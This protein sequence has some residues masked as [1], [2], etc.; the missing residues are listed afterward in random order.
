MATADEFEE[1][2]LEEDE[3]GLLEGEFEE[4]KSGWQNLKLKA[5]EHPRISCGGC[6]LIVSFAVDVFIRFDPIVTGLGIA[7]A[8]LVGW[9]GEDLLHAFIPAADPDQANQ[10]VTQMLDNYPMYKDQSPKAKI[11]RLF[12]QGSPELYEFAEQEEEFPIQQRRQLPPPSQRREVKKLSGENVASRQE[13][14]TDERI[15]TWF[16]QGVI[17]DEQLIRLLRHIEKRSSHGNRDGNGNATT[18]EHEAAPEEAVS[19]QMEPL[20]PVGWDEQKEFRFAGAFLAINHVDDSLKAI[21]FSTSQR[22]RDYA[23]NLLKQ[24]G[25]LKGK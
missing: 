3:T 9:K 14:L 4:E 24:Q 22:N 6:T 16:E 10:F 21:G 23:R 17:D 20:R 7:A 12:R 2:E 18:D 1:L 15:I 13:G 25:L 5:M 11:M 8:C 19:T